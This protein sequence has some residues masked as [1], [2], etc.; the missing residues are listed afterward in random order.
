MYWRF[1][2]CYIFV[3]FFYLLIY[4]LKYIYSGYC[5][6]CNDYLTLYKHLLNID[7]IAVKGQYYTKVGIKDTLPQKEKF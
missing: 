2:I 6:D 1:I 7:S 5:N 4:L 3:L